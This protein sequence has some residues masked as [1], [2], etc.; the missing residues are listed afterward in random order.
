VIA[1]EYHDIVKGRIESSL[2]RGTSDRIEAEITTKRAGEGSGLGLAAVHGIVKSH[3]GVITAESEMGRGTSFCIHLPNSDGPARPAQA[4]EHET[5]KGT[6]SILFVDDEEQIGALSGSGSKNWATEA[7]ECFRSRPD[8]FDLVITDQTMPHM[9]GG[10]LAQEILKIRPGMPVILCTGF[11][12]AVTAEKAQDLGISAYL[13][14][15]VN[16]DELGKTVHRL[17][18]Q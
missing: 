6:G 12:E 7:L 15:P 2:S 10:Q 9:T 8:E 4:P 5:P 1:P 17:V 13:Q 14:K 11:S 18:H 16:F 3:G